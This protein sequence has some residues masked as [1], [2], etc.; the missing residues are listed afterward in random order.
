MALRGTTALVLSGGG[1]LGA[2]QVGM[3]GA[4]AEAGVAFDMVIGTSVGAINAAW[5]ASSGLGDLE[6]LAD[7]WRGMQRADVFPASPWRAA[8]AAAGRRRSLVSDT[9]LRSV[10]ERH[11][12]FARLEDAPIPLHVV[13]VDALT[14]ESRVFSRGPAIEAV[15]A[16]AAIPGLLPPVRIGAHW[17]VDGGVVD[18]CPI[19]HGVALGADRLWVLPAGY[20]C[21]PPDLPSG[22]VAMA[23]QGVALLVQHGLALDVERYRGD[24][25][26]RVVPPPCPL[27]VSPSDFSRGSELIAAGRRSAHQWLDASCPDVRAALSVPHPHPPAPVVAVVR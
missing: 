1:S 4:L 12:R 19:G 26:L 8:M 15:L 6:G 22:A 16:S 17:Y 5:V 27:S 20:P 24:V 10:L 9:G 3:L 11:V 7:V 2:V 14:G 23:L 21:A 13:A 18:N 25:D